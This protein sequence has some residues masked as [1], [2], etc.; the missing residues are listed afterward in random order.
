MARSWGPRSRTTTTSAARA[1]F[2]ATLLGAVLIIAVAVALG[3]GANHFSGRGI[4]LLPAHVVESPTIPLP[5]GVEG[6]DFAEVRTAFE[7]G[8]ALFLDARPTG[9]Y[10]EGHIPGALSLPPDEFEQRFV[11]LIDSITEAPALIIYCS[12]EEC[13]DSIALAERLLE[14]RDTGIY[15]FEAG[16]RAWRRAGAPVGIGGQP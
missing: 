9:D 4:P 8:S 14:T 5:R 11:E 13:S 1:D 3:L 7:A 2:A 15:V 6:L 10:A 16:W 12:G